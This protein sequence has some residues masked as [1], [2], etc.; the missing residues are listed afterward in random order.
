VFMLH[1]KESDL[2]DKTHTD[3]LFFAST[4]KGIINTNENYRNAPT[5]GIFIQRKL[6]FPTKNFT[7]KNSIITANVVIFFTNLLRYIS[8]VSPVIKRA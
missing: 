3:F 4:K 2:I 1:K 6:V 7:T 5:T 8:F